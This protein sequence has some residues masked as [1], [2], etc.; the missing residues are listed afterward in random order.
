MDD[1]HTT[2]AYMIQYCDK[3]TP[4]PSPQNNNNNNKNKGQLQLK[5][6]D[7]IPW[8]MISELSFVIEDFFFLCMFTYGTM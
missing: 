8:K 2:C 6:Y 4:P 7:L 3:V 5:G 1:R